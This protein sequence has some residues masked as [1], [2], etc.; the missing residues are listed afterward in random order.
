MPDHAPALLAPASTFHGRYEIVRCIRAG[1]MGAVYEV[2]HKE[3]RR[4]RA[5]KVMLPSMVADPELRARFKLEATITADIDSEHIVET[6]DAGV[7]AETGAPFLVMELLKGEDLS[8]ILEERKRLPAEEVVVLLHQAGLALDKTHA[9]GIVHR[10]LKP[11]NMF[12]TSRD[13]GSPR[14]KI[15]DFGIAKVVANAT[16]AK[17]T[18]SM[19]TPLYMSPE[20]V[21]GDGAIDASSDLY[22]L[23]HIAYTL[24]VGSA[25]W[26]EDLAQSNGIYP[27]LMKIAMGQVEP[28]VERASR[29]G[30]TL[31]PAFEA[32]FAKAASK[33][34]SER[35]ER[36]AELVGELAGVFSVPIPKALAPIEAMSR[37]GGDAKGK[38]KKV[39]RP[40]HLAGKKT[41]DTKGRAAGIGTSPPEPLKTSEIEAGNRAALNPGERR[42]RGGNTVGAVSADASPKSRRAASTGGRQPSRRALRVAA[43]LAL[44]GFAAVAWIAMR[45]RGAPHASET[46]SVAAGL[47]A[48]ASIAP[49]SASAPAT[50]AAS[51]STSDLPVAATAVASAS[52]ASPSASSAPSA[53]AVPA[54]KRPPRTGRPSS[55][56]KPAPYDPTTVR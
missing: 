29:A 31:P 12:V 51:A 43:A 16:N 28:A 18:R 5:L 39:A 20:Q 35:F 7:D 45:G 19:G 1:G 42:A 52:A 11:E 54:S 37:R 49:P 40:T 48:S 17:S 21:V 9:A 36:A 15:L 50:S 3:T 32:W 56:P 24:L 46:A 26:D 13:D 22:A 44:V 53:S 27:L 47:P 33:T 8:I 23:A 10:D 30:V 6:F 41:N 34:A 2:I 55:K 4:R 38:K 25:Y 14:L